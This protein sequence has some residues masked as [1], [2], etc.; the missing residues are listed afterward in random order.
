MLFYFYFLMIYVLLL[1]TSLNLLKKNKRSIQ[2]IFKYPIQ[3]KIS[4]KSSRTLKI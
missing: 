1:I 4:L 3:L 2:I